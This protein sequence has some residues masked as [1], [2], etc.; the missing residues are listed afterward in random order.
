[1]HQQTKRDWIHISTTMPRPCKEREAEYHYKSATRTIFLVAERHGISP[2]DI[3]SNGRS[4]R[5]VRARDEAIRIVADEWPELSLT[6]IGRIFN[7]DHSTIIHSLGKT[8][9]PGKAR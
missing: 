8:W 2:C 9:V 4:K 5:F 3:R 1:M 6:S 7:R